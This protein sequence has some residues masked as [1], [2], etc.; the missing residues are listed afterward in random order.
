MPKTKL[1]I[2]TAKI[3]AGIKKGKIDLKKA[4]ILIADLEAQMVILMKK[5]KESKAA[6]KKQRKSN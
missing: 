3:L 5:V 1:E 4:G 6:R 2:A